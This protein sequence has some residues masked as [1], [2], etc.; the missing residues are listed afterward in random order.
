MFSPLFSR[1]GISDSRLHLLLLVLSLVLYKIYLLE[2]NSRAIFN[3][4]WCLTGK[5]IF[6]ELQFVILLGTIHLLAGF[7]RWYW[8]RGILRLTLIAALIIMAI[9][10]MVLQQFLVRFTLHE[11][12]RFISEFSAIT[13]FLKQLLANP[14]NAIFSAAAISVILGIFSRYLRDDHVTSRS[15]VFLAC[16]GF[17]IFGFQYLKPVEYHMPYLQNSIE[18][19]FSTQTRNRPYSENFTRNISAESNEQLQCYAGKGAR[20]DLILLVVESLSMYHSALLSG[21]NNWA[22]QF[23]TLSQKGRW[24]SNFYANGIN[25]E[26]GLIA[27]HIGEPPIAKG[28][29]GASEIGNSTALLF[30]QFLD[31]KDSLPRMLNESGYHTVFLTTGNLGFLGK[32]KWLKNIGYNYIEGHDAPYYTGMKRFHFDAP[33]D[34]AL[35]GR[36]L[37]ELATHNQNKKMP[38]FMTLETVSTHHPFIDPESGTQSEEL[39][40]RYADRQLGI[41]VKNLESNGFFDNGYLLIVSDHRAMVPMNQSEID[42]FGNRAYTRIPFTIIG[43]G[44]DEGEESGYFSQSDL[45]PSLRHWLN[46][47]YQCVSSNQGIF[48]PNATQMPACIVT[49]RSYNLDNVFIHCGMEDYTINLNGDHTSYIDSIRPSTDFLGVIHRLRLGKGY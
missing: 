35:Y 19:F 13:D 18:A 38:V 20:P 32:G 15:P 33:S 24:F 48:L 44:L 21:I 10:L 34:S 3:C 46:E 16:F 49:H 30:E 7:S 25:T 36:A 41:F 39:T 47:G 37:Q 14:W 43:H 11:F 27:L 23:D 26:Q 8:L 6:F 5:A 4:Q 31:P 2:I 22:P 9:D 17:C 28:I 42:R 1:K 45:L 29:N 40:F 12:S